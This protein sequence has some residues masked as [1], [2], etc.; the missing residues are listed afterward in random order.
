MHQKRSREVF[1]STFSSVPKPPR[2]D[3]S[4]RDPVPPDQSENACY[5]PVIG[6]AAPVPIETPKQDYTWSRSPWERDSRT[7]DSGADSVEVEQDERTEYVFYLYTQSKEFTQIRRTYTVFPWIQ[8]W[9]FI[10][11]RNPCTP[12][13]KPGQAKIWGRRLIVRYSSRAKWNYM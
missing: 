10:S 11:L 4:S 8:A 3:R 9:A 7:V 6:E 12:A 5:G 13:F 1:S 2:R